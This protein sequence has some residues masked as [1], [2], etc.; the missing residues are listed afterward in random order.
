MTD[1][2]PPARRRALI[3]GASRGIGDALA[4]AAPPDMDLLLVA[5]DADALEA[6]AEA[7]RARGRRVDVHAV[8]IAAP[9]G[10]ASLIDD[11][12]GRIDV[13]VNNAGVGAWGGFLDVDAAAH[14]TAV[15]VNVAAP[16][17]LARALLP[18][19]IE[20]A[21]MMGGRAGLVNMASSLAFTP[22]PGFAV[23]AAGK[24]YLLS[25]TEA[26]AA[27]FA[28]DPI[29]VMAVCPGAVSTEFGA[30]AG[31]GGAIPGAM[32][33]E[34]VARETWRALGRRRTLVLGPVDAA[35]FTPAALARSV[36]AE[37]AARG[38]RL[39]ELLNRR[40]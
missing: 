22:V 40:R 29:D 39:A 13:L 20:R 26:L 30:R 25:L 38:G 3:T 2:D 23:Y 37:V 4:R 14:E 16:T 21:R 5:R 7:E 33:P 11:A 15:A 32:A 19:M 31:F 8:D 36:A 1:A 18:G 10:R 34:S 35:L 27:E 24:A 9:E 6:V 28:S 17:A 12:D